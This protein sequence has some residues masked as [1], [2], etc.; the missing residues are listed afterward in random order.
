MGTVMGADLEILRT[1]LQSVVSR[2]IENMTFEEA[3][4]VETD[5]APCYEDESL[6]ASLSVIYPYK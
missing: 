5:G 3:V 2:T 1:S 4:V 6:W